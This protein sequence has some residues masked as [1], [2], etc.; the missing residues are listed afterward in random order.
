MLF[1]I[2]D[3]TGRGDPRPMGT[4]ESRDNC[5]PTMQE[6]QQVLLNAERLEPRHFR[7]WIVAVY[8]S[9]DVCIA[10]LHLT[11]QSMKDGLT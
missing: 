4:V 10:E 1:Y 6:I 7:P 2:Q 9:V 8:N 3:W 5:L 11:V